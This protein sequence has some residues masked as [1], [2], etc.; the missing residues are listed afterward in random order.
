MT[1]MRFDDVAPWAH[2]FNTVA[3]EAD[4]GEEYELFKEAHYQKLLYSAS[5]KF[6]WLPEA[7]SSWYAATPLSLRDYLGTPDGSLYGIVKDYTD[8]VKTIV[9]ARTKIPNLF[10]TGQ[11]LNLHGILGAS[12]SA[13]ATCVDVLGTDDFVTKIR[14]A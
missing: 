14:E 13:M 5:E 2:T 12:I 10:L 8:P 1:Y 11:N 4:R 7:V 3:A 9:A 6:P